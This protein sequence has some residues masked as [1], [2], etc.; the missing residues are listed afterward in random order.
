MMMLCSKYIHLTTL[1]ALL[2]FVSV[3]LFNN[4]HFAVSIANAHS[5]HLLTRD[6]LQLNTRS[7][8]DTAFLAKGFVRNV[9]RD[10]ASSPRMTKG[11]SVPLPSK[12]VSFGNVDSRSSKK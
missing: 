6:S 10:Q 9:F 3:A 5:T 7:A 2:T 1:S 8:H 4:H 11:I 12:P